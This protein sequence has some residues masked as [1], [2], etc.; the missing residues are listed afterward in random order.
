MLATSRQQSVCTK[1][2]IHGD[3]QI[4]VELSKASKFAFYAL[5]E[6]NMK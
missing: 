2:A 3:S 5:K 4:I 6:K 1:G